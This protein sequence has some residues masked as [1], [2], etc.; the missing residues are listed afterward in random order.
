[1]NNNKNNLNHI[2]ILS[3]EN[4]NVVSA[5]FDNISQTH[6]ITNIV[7]KNNALHSE[8]EIMHDRLS[9]IRRPFVIIA[10]SY[11]SFVAIYYAKMY[12]KKVKHIMLLGCPPFDD[13]YN[14]PDEPENASPLVTEVSKL[15]KHNKLIHT[16]KKV[17]CPITFIHGK[18]DS[19]P[20]EGVQDVLN[21]NDVDFEF[22]L[23]DKC[24]A[25]PWNDEQK[26]PSL[27]KM[28]NILIDEF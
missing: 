11:N 6:N 1:M 19:N 9:K 27:F 24:G 14:N 7:V 26:A 12:A 3:S 20:Y 25:M 28:L 18:Q 10:N 15:R 23:Y 22:I 17:K 4:K 16:I 5:I 2:V 21:K 8:I 13:E